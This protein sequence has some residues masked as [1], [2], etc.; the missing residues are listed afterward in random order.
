MLPNKL[1]RLQS[2]VAP[3]HKT[4]EF[5]SGYGFYLNHARGLTDFYISASLRNQAVSGKP[6]LLSFIGTPT[7]DGRYEYSF[8]CHG[9]SLIGGRE[10]AEAML[11]TAAEN[12]S[13]EASLH[14]D[15]LHFR[16][17]TNTPLL[18]AGRVRGSYGERFTAM[19]KVSAP[20]ES[21][22]AINSGIGL[23]V[24]SGGAF[25]IADT[26]VYEGGEVQMI[27]TSSASRQI[28][29]ISVITTM[30]KL[31]VI[32]LNSFGVFRGAVGA[33]DFA[34]YWGSKASVILSE[35][36]CVC[37]T[38]RDYLY[39]MRGYAERFTEAY[40]LTLEGLCEASFGAS[41]PSFHAPIPE[42]LIGKTYNVDCLAMPSSESTFLSTPFCVRT[43]A[44][45]E[46]LELTSS[47]NYDTPEKYLAL[48]QE[49]AA[50]AIVIREK[51]RYEFFDPIA[52]ETRKGQNYLDTE[53]S[54]VPHRL[55]IT[56]Y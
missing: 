22:K 14:G 33:E 3:T 28:V 25:A 10:L 44:D 24:S 12:N 39:P 32:D 27:G 4:K 26:A 31:R 6:S 11:R 34:P 2:G 5:S 41:V 56:Y 23:T 45:G 52:I 48:M 37:D 20:E 19:L 18:P 53:T 54:I 16:S 36:L 40:P 1:K 8:H 13:L 17:N 47:A 49:Y 7:A 46:Y 43:S 51:P 15:Y 38:T 29:N 35:P 30:G 21:G 50:K 42:V 9:E 55:G